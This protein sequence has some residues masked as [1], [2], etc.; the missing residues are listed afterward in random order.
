MKHKREIFD[1]YLTDAI[2]IA[3]LIIVVFSLL[4]ITHYYMNLRVFR[5]NLVETTLH[6]TTNYITRT[7]KDVNET[8]AYASYVLAGA[9]SS[10]LKL[11]YS[12]QDML[13]E[14]QQA[15]QMLSVKN[16]GLVDIGKNI[17]LDSLGQ[18]LALDISS[19]RD[20]WI[21]EFVSRPEDYRYNFY[22]PD[23]AEY[24]TL[25]SFFHDHK[26][27]DSDGKV[28]G[29]LGVGIDYEVFY[30]RIKGLDD[31]ISV[32]FVTQGGEV[33]LP[34]SLKGKSIFSLVP[35]MKGEQFQSAKNEDQIFWQ[36][37]D[38]Q[39]FLV[40][41]HYLKDINRVLLLKL[42]V[43]KY[44]NESK[45]QHFY[46]FLLG[47]VLT[48]LVVIANLVISSYQS[49]KLQQSAFY[50]SLTQ[51]R[52]R[53]YLENQI[54]KNSYWQFIKQN[55][56]SMIVFDVDYFKGVNDT[57]GHV[58]GD[59]VLKHVAEIVKNS[60]R[61]SDEFLRLGGDEFVILLNLDTQQ[62]NA[63]AN[64]INQ[65]VTKE[66]RVSLSM[67]ITGISVH[68]SFDSAM[69]RADS[70]LYQAKNNGRKQVAVRLVDNV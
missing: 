61:E 17:Y 29:I 33:R 24:E 39:T 36:H 69:E 38:G 40:Y 41:F 56:Y 32:A 46:S 20:K 25:Y 3:I 37:S 62:A 5:D 70:A 26:I 51:C 27:K 16:V 48:I 53:N 35:E 2:R 45:I 52:N 11:D 47:L 49:K 6:R 65:H 60:L 7:L 64:R 23:E 10:K 12:T 43:T 1:G 30:Q 19:E 14:L 31:K 21:Q 59:R 50:D 44:Y 57:Y 18:V 63:I 54:K 22:D 67:G 28:L 15:M 13:A 4:N 8:Y 66:T 34:K 58:E 68:D 42:D 9:Y 55:G